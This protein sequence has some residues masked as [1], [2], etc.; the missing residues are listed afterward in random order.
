MQPIRSQCQFALKALVCCLDPTLQMVKHDGDDMFCSIRAELGDAR[1]PAEMHED[2]LR[3]DWLDILE[4]L[5]RHAFRSFD[6]YGRPRS[7]LGR[8]AADEKLG[9]WNIGDLRPTIEDSFY[10]R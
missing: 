9:E 3:M 2:I 6:F 5:R 10:C 4:L 8:D 7:D 1:A